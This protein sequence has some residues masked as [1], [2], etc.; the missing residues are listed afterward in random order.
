AVQPRGD[1]VQR[2]LHEG[3]VDGRAAAVPDV[4]A[5]PDPQ[6]CDHRTPLGQDVLQVH[7][8]SDVAPGDAAQ[9]DRVVRRWIDHDAFEALLEARARGRAD[10]GRDIRDAETHAHV[11]RKESEIAPRAAGAR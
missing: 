5:E 2:V 10:L 3:A 7:V 9:A 4:R 6:V 11:W 1:R 8:P